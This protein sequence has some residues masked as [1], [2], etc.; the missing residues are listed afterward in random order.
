MEFIARCVIEAGAR[1]Y[2]LQT[3]VKDLDSVFREVN[4]GGD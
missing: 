1:L 4:A 3:V 2:Q